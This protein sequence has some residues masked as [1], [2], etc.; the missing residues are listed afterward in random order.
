MREPQKL[1][2]M[3]NLTN[4]VNLIGYLGMDPE[5]KEFDN[6]GKMLRLSLAT[7]HSYKNAEGKKV[8]D[9]HWHTVVGWG[10]T[11]ELGQ[12]LLKKGKQ[13]AVD[14]ML[15]TRNYQDKEGNKRY[16]TE[17]RLDNFVLLGKKDD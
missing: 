9:T 1:N 10:K 15:I 16:A 13:V 12:Q 11:A 5:M 17:V 2:V 14:G 6:G 8:E 4:N 3:K 7:N